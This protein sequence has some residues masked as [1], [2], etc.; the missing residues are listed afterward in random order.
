VNIDKEVSELLE[1][2]NYQEYLKTSYWKKLS[3]LVKEKAGNK[4]QVCN[5]RL[6]LNAH[7]RSYLNKGDPDKEILDLICL[8]ENCHSL[9]HKKTKKI[10]KKK[11]KK[12]TSKVKNRR[13]RKARVKGIVIKEGSLVGGKTAEEWSKLTG[14]KITVELSKVIKKM[15]EPTYKE[16]LQSRADSGEKRAINILKHKK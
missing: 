1:P 3:K 4:C 7:H 6:S 9:F 8:C 11:P 12:R 13:R 15:P 14:K 2:K 10:K 16:M 5:S